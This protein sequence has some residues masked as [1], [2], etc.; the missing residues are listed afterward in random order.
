MNTKQLAAHDRHYGGQDGSH[1]SESLFS[2]LD[3]W[4]ACPYPPIDTELRELT[5]ALWAKGLAIVPIERH[6]YQPNIHLT[7]QDVIDEEADVE[8]FLTH[9]VPPLQQAIVHLAGLLDYNQERLQN[10]ISTDTKGFE[11]GALNHLEDAQ[12]SVS[13]RIQRIKKTISYIE[14]VLTER[15]K[16]GRRDEKPD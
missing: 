7:I 10:L 4:D 8:S 15:A 2:I 5:L 12:D 11:E 9:R 14:L 1:I 16:E 13:Q 3:A 6:I